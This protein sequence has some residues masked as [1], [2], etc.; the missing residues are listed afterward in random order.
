MLRRTRL[1]TIWNWFIL[2]FSFIQTRKLS[3]IIT[4]TR[5][6]KSSTKAITGRGCFLTADRSSSSSSSSCKQPGTKLLHDRA[7][8]WKRKAVFVALAL[9]WNSRTSWAGRWTLVHRTTKQRQ[10][11]IRMW[12][13]I[14]KKIIY[15]KIGFNWL[16]EAKLKET[17]EACQR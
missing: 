4:T 9:R 15:L 17:S 6:T 16:S 2:E 3:T 14:Y 1:R 13:V 5:L 10:K 8:S 7:R 11:G 12:H